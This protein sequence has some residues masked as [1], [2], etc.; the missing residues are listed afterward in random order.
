MEKRF[1]FL[2]LLLCCL[3]S[4]SAIAQ[5][6]LRNVS[7]QEAFSLVKDNFSGQDV[8]YYLCE[9]PVLKIEGENNFPD[10]SQSGTWTFFVDAEPMKG[11]EHDCYIVRVVKRIGEY[12]SPATQSTKFR[13]PPMGN[14]SPL[15]VKNRYGIK[16]N[17]KPYV[18]KATLSNE[19]KSAAGHT[20]AVILSGGHNK[21]SNYERYWNDCS[22][23]YQT[24]V[25]KYGVP[26]NNIAVVMSDGTNPAED[27]RLTTGGY[28]SSPLD[29]DYDGWPDI[30]YAATPV[31]NQI[32]DSRKFSKK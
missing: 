17:Q 2:F 24:L 20:Y 18:R 12:Q 1:K 16:A 27:M 28:K 22:F 29:L 9:D 21:Y 26:K 19:A 4:S 6:R 8:D 13:L 10:P 31:D 30:K 5:Q 23:V 11:W 15:E 7:K 14:F 25:N 3:I 32:V